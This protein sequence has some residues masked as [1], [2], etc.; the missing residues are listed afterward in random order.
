MLNTMHRAPGRTDDTWQHGET[1]GVVYVATGARYLAEAVRSA[2]SLKKLMPTTPVTL[3]TDEPEAAAGPF[4]RV[5]RVSEPRH[6]FIDKIL[7]LLESTYDRTLFLDSDTFVCEPLDALFAVLDRFDLAASHDSWRG[8]DPLGE[9][10]D[11][12]ADLNTGVLLYRRTPAVV[13][14]IRAW[15]DR[16]ANLIATGGLH[17]GADALNDQ[18]AFRAELYASDVPFY[19]LPPEYNLTV[20]CPGFAGTKAR[21]AIV[22]GRSRR[23]PEIARIVNESQEARAFLPSLWHVDRKFLGIYSRLGDRLLAVEATLRRGFR[24]LFPR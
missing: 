20:W 17:V 12:F 4:D 13:R 22:H 8:P 14:F 11:A 24:R 15:H 18:A 19:A 5:A 10:P 9:C 7:P 23:L 2:A 3:F 21:V 16:Y 1:C 6:G